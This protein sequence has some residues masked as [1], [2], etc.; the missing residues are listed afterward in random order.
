MNILVRTED[1]ILGLYSRL[2]FS[3][4]AN[5]ISFLWWHSSRTSECKHQVLRPWSSWRLENSLMIIYFHQ[6]S[7]NC[8]VFD[9]DDLHSIFWL[10]L[11]KFLREKSSFGNIRETLSSI[12]EGT[13]LIYFFR[14]FFSTFPNK[15]APN[16]ENRIK[17]IYHISLYFSFLIL[18]LILLILI[19]LLE[20]I[21]NR[22]FVSRQVWKNV[23]SF[24][25]NDYIQEL[26]S[27]RQ[28]PSDTLDLNNR[29][30][31]KKEDP[32]YY[33]RSQVV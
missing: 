32:F 17:F 27:S 26:C 13:L 29:L 20:C 28:I 18:F 5:I 10:I 24:T 3:N 15:T 2:M 19:K 14:I 33:S 12:A 21:K 30:G 16:L 11:L 8:I 6:S 4:S 31:K 22:K 9:S 23:F 7:L 1:K 25:N